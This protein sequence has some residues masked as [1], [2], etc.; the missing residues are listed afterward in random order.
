MESFYWRLLVQTLWTVSTISLRINQ[1]H[2][3][4][5]SSTLQNPKTHLAHSMTTME[6]PQQHPS[7]QQSLLSPS[8]TWT[9][10][11][12]DSSWMDHQSFYPPVIV[13]L[14]LQ[15]HS[16][17]HIEQDTHQQAQLAHH[18]LDYMQAIWQWISTWQ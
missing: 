6:S 18:S 17:N 3:I 12:R 15:R 13:Q 2:K 7:W 8:G 10:Q 16:T 9:N 14:S 1:N 11:S 5:C 4:H